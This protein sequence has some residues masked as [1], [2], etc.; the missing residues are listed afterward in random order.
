MPRGEQ[1]RLAILDGTLRVIAQGGVDAVTHRRVA[2]TAGVSLSST[3]Y[4]FATREEMILAAFRHHIGNTPLLSD[5]REQAGDIDDAIDFLVEY[6]ERQLAHPGMLRAEYELILYTVREPR[7]SEAYEAWHRA[8][9]SRIA[10]ALE[11]LGTPRPVDAARLVA[12]VV[13][14]FEIEYLTR[15]RV[16]IDDL[17]RRLEL[18]LPA[19]VPT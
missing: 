2:A 1:R 16:V 19:L 3:T 14:A 5:R 17:R 6:C 13:R 9:E 12:G 11:R 18:L 4:Y 10:E 8:Q 15:P 7:L